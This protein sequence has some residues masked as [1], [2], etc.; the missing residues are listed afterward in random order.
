ME[1]SE[2]DGKL[3][4]LASDDGEGMSE[5]VLSRVF[6][7]FYS[8]SPVGGTGL[9]LVIVKN[10]VEAHRGQLLVQS[11]VGSGTQITITLPTRS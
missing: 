1:V 7:P 8:S 10:I 5:E 2:N 9:G 6:E 3:T 11:E 4:I